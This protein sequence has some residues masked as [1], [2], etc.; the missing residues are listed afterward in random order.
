M[1][2]VA[3]LA[4]RLNCRH[5]AGH[6]L[7]ALVLMTDSRRLPDPGPAAERLPAGSLV[8][9]RHYED[10][11]RKDRLRA[12]AR[13]CR[14]R[15]LGLL[16]AGDWRLALACGADGV[17][18]PERLVPRGRGRRRKRGWLVTAAAHSEAALKRAAAAG[19]D[20]VLLAP[21]FA[22]ASHPGAPSLGPL[23]FA[24][25]VRRSALPVYALGGID[26]RTARRLSGSGAVGIAGIAALSE[27]APR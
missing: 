20:A 18:L 1:S 17:H 26:R 7:P 15:R 10:A 23:R 19:V 24:R 12:L 6:R 14:R 8:I 3:N 5:P 16:V 13:I 4:E 2:T 25:L 9:F 11:S 27:M 21:V 22:T